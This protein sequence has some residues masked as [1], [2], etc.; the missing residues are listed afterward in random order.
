LKFLASKEGSK[1]H[2]LCASRVPD[3]AGREV[4]AAVDDKTD[5]DAKDVDLAARHRRQIETY[6]RARSVVS[7]KPTKAKVIG[8]R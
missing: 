1:H 6:E 2:F 8:A 4:R 7:G 5:A 3:Q